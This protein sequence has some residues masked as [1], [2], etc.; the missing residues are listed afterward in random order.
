MNTEVKIFRVWSLQ[1]HLEEVI[2]VDISA[3]VILKH[4]PLI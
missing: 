3:L 4:V 2:F 1:C